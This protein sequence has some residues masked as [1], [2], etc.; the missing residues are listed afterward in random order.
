MKTLIYNTGYFLL[1]AKRTIR[2]NLLSNLF[3]VISTG[4]IL[5]LLAMVLTGWRVG[6]EL[7][8][9]LQGEAQVSAYFT[10]TLA[11]EQAIEIVTTIQAMEG[12]QKAEYIDASQAYEINQRLLG[13]EA[14][15]LELFEENPFEAYIDIRIHLEEMDQVLNRISGI[16][17]IEYVRDNR[18]V[19]VKLRSIVTII[20]VVGILIAAAVGMTTL[21]IISHMIRQGIYNNKELINT[22]RLL[23]A[24]GSFIGFPFIL[25]GTLLTVMGGALASLL[26]IILMNQGY[27]QVSSN[28]MFLPLPPME[29]LRNDISII[30][31]VISVCL[32]IA[33]SLF[34]VSSIRK[35]GR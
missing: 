18:D 17:G 3:S 16:E 21:I 20:K 12:V 8:E 31:I 11:K 19:L 33:G 13:N 2:L 24:P 10:G 1:E 29:E 22:L 26:I 6:D 5:F 28:I 23:G 35:A 34:G 7:I 25:A 4:L 15:I 30:I 14:K 9:A 32:G 27:G